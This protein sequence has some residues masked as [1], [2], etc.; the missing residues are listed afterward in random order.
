METGR[1]IRPTDMANI[2]A[3]MELDTRAFG[4]K[5]NSTDMAKRSGLTILAMKVILKMV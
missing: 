3:M 5:I 2:K 4:M 1:M